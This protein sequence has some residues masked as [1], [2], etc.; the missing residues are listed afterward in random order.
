MKARQLRYGGN[1]AVLVL[2]VLGIL[3]AVNYIA[4]RRPLKKDLTANK[5]FTL[6]DQTL[7]VVGGLKE[8]VR[9]LYFQRAAELL[10]AD[11]RLRQYEALSPRLK[12][13]F[14]DPYQAPTRARDYGITG[15]L[16]TIVVERGARRERASSDSE[17]DLTNAIVKVTRDGQK[18]VCFAEGEGERDVEDGG[19]GGYTGAKE[20][21]TRSN[22]LTKKVV[23][24]RERAV[25]ADCSMIVVAGPQIDLLPAVVDAV[26]A[27]VAGGGKALVMAEPPFKAAQPNLDGL[28][29][30]WSLQAGKDV[31]I[32][33][34][35]M[36]QLMGLDALSPLV[37]DYPYHEITKGFRVMT[38][39][40]EARSLQAATEGGLPGVSAQNIVQTSPASWAESDLTLKQPV[41][42]GPGDK[43]GPIALAAVATITVTG[44]P[45]SPVPSPGPGEEAPP[46][47]EGRVAAFG[48]ADFASNAFLANPGNRDFFLNVVAWLSEDADLISIRPREPEDQRLFLTQVQQRIVG[49]V[50]LLFLP[51]V[52]VALGV[53]T[54]WKRR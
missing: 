30:S 19:D 3:G 50:A 17:Q 26:R 36:G 39:F 13:E 14:V 34:S 15:P 48:D 54:W 2:V 23:L 6:S 25:P 45:P 43:P 37:V 9:V 33:S 46:S 12:A 21:L 38:V 22:Y 28:L 51:G 10:G 41:S 29:A 16:P 52:F 27:H 24:A 1:S 18:T 20:A 40:H 32:D 35:G 8:D 4:Y 5:R 53:W 44:A 49:F 47:R 11:E 7:K 31:V 42:A